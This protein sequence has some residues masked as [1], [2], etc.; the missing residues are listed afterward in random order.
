MGLSPA[1]KFIIHV[2]FGISLRLQSLAFLACPMETK[3]LLALDRWE[4][5]MIKKIKW[6]VICVQVFENYNVC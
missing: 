3:T 6:D 1:L 5:E 2:T 4:D